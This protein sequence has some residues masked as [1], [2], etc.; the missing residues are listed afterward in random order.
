MHPP[1]IFLDFD[2]VISR[3]QPLQK[4][5]SYRDMFDRDRI[6]LLHEF[7]EK[8][9]AEVVI[10]SDWRMHFDYLEIISLLKPEITRLHTSW[11]THVLRAH[12]SVEDSSVPRGA[13]IITWLYHHPE[14][15][16][17]VIFD[18]LP[19]YEFVGLSHHHVHCEQ[20][21]NKQHLKQAGEI[22]GI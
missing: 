11:C 6:A 12:T 18:D 5:M 3:P 7:I 14:T 8:T 19:A 17:H 16:R 4:G 1:I 15:T 10:S 13:E 20:P 9:E 2:G 22:L 21:L